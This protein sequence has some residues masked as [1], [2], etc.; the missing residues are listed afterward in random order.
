VTEIERKGLKAEQTVSQG[1]IRG[2]E[3]YTSGEWTEGKAKHTQK[4]W[5]EG[6]RAIQI[7][8][9]KDRLGPS[10]RER[11]RDVTK[12][13]AL[14]GGKYNRAGGRGAIHHRDDCKKKHS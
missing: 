6:R 5:I 1:L 9:K 4:G 10:D 2:G 12:G 7:V 11:A 3:R 13:Q 8:K 14:R